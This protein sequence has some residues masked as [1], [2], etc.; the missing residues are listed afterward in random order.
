MI[1]PARAVIHPML[2]AAMSERVAGTSTCACNWRKVVAL[3]IDT[4]RSAT[5][6]RLF[7]VV[8]WI[9]RGAQTGGPDDACFW[10]RLEPSGLL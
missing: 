9:T 5:L 2:Q 4:N 3:Y 10:E 6:T 8:T 1:R 7:T